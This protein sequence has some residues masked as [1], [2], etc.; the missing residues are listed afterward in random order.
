MSI[1]W[2]LREQG[3]GAGREELSLVHSQPVSK[4]FKEEDG[5]PDVRRADAGDGAG[6]W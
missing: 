3:V 6:G 5:R 2:L 1:F 4:H